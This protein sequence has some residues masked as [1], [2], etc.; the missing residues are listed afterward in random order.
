MSDWGIEYSKLFPGIGYGG[1]CFPKDVRTLIRMGHENN[2]PMTII[3]S[4]QDVNHK[5]QEHFVEQILRYFNNRHNQITLGIWGLAFKANTNDIRESP[6]LYAISKFLNANIKIRAYDPQAMSTAHIYFDGQIK[7]VPNSY[8]ALNSADALVI[9]TDWPEFK[10]PDFDVIV[11]RL[12]RPVIFDGRNLYDP[13]CVRKYGIAYYS[14]G[15]D[16]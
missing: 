13:A 14:I 8:D 2:C 3:K 15:R 9:F 10:T 7:T 1:S 5:Q 6:A 11:N 4:V 12:K 16:G